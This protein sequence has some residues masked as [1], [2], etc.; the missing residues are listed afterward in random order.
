MSRLMPDIAL[1]LAARDEDVEAA[2]RLRHEV[3]VEEMGAVGPTVDHVRRL[4]RDRFDPH[5]EHLLLID[6]L[7]G[8]AVGTARLMDVEGAARAGGFATEAEFDIAPLRRSGRRLLEVGRTCLRRDWRGGTALLRLWQGVA[9]RAE[10][11]GAELLFGLASFPGTDPATHAEALALI[12]RECLAPESLRPAAHRPVPLD[13]WPDRPLDRRAAALALP[14]LVKTYLRLG[15]WAGEGA[16]ADPDL[17]L[18]DL[19]MVLDTARLGQRARAL[20]APR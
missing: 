16:C 4:E 6:R 17:G 9:R 7:R 3:F 11:A 13:P 14:P 1:R 10:A 2:Q 12:A 8:E 18:L 19:C 15:A 20:L 5:C